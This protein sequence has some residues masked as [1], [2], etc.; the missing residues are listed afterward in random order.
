MTDVHAALCRH[1][2]DVFE[3]VLTPS[4]PIA[5]PAQTR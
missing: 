4:E 1:L 5:A 3:R 2:C